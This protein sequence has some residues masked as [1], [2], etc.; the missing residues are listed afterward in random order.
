MLNNF[1]TYTFIVECGFFV[2]LLLILSISLYI[3][4]KIFSRQRF[5]NKAIDYILLKKTAKPIFLLIYLLLLIKFISRIIYFAT[6]NQGI[7]LFLI[8]QIPQIRSLT[9]IIFLTIAGYIFIKQAKKNYINI[10]ANNNNKKLDP[11]LIDLFSK[12]AFLIL[13]SIS[14]LAIMQ[15]LGV[16][17]G[18]LATLGGA[19]GVIIGFATK[20]F[21]G[22]IAGLI[23]IYLDKPF[24][25]GDDITIFNNSGGV[26]ANGVVEEI[27]VRLTL[28]RTIKNK[29]IVFVPNSIFTN[30][31]LENNSRRSH[32]FFEESF[33]VNFNGNFK[34]INS[35]IEALKKKIQ[36]YHFVDS[37]N[38][39]ILVQIID[40]SEKFVY[41]TVKV[42]F[43]KMDLENFTLKSNTLLE[44]ILNIFNHYN[45]LLASKDERFIFMNENGKSQEEDSG[46]DE[47][48]EDTE[49]TEDTGDS[50]A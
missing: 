28:I 22:S 27:N 4:C 19:S 2:L 29:S 1:L 33:K 10:H 14:G 16:G 5:A 49:E 50:H 42:F 24:I 6:D 20:D 11:Y 3:S 13:F 17:F 25:I 23:S 34:K 32:R 7:K 21:F 46:E 43:V 39:K 8:E 26:V 18:A 30:N 31:I 9:T 12:I 38:Q 41:L 47:D 45:L 15:K 40:A 35:M 44:S 36:G 48:T 37:I